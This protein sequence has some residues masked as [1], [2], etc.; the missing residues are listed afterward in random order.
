MSSFREPPPRP[1]LKWVGG[2]RQLVPE[3]LKVVEAAKPYRRYHEPFF[4]GGA[5]FF[6]LARTGQLT[7]KPRVSDVNKNLIEAY[8]A[9]RDDVE[10]VVKL[11]REHK[12]RHCESYYYEVRSNVPRA[13]TKKAARLIYLN[14][15]C[16]NGLYREN[17]KGKFNAPLGRYKNP[18]ICDEENLRAVSKTLA[19]ISIEACS[20]ASVLTFA[21]RG[22]L[23]YFDPPYQPISETAFFTAYSKKGFSETAQKE[24]AEAFARLANRGVK[25]ILSNS[26]TDF[27]VEL[28]NKSYFVYQVFA[29]RFVNSKADRRGKIPEALITSFPL[30]VDGE[31]ILQLNVPFSPSDSGGIERMLAKEWLLQNNYTAIAKL[32]DEVVAEWKAQGKATRR[33][34]WEILAG[35]TNGNPRII[36][37]R[38][39]PVLRTAQLRQ[40]VPVSSAA[41]CHNPNEEAPP[42]RVTTRWSRRS[43]N[44]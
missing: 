10:T 36:A 31:R 39:F 17:S 2:K 14:R 42:I 9:V 1:F 40:G 27:T 41:L 23:V 12:A 43:K 29:N 13:L 38:A 4:G 44:A 8:L 35:D 22:D 28:Y 33:N 11:L 19:G 7:G 32:I 3:L 25:V 21:K 16:F 20:F 5:L 26:I 37:G 18:T 34:W 24:L 6:A 30:P 15:T